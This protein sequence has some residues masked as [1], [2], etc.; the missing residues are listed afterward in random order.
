MNPNGV[1]HHSP[2][3]RRSRYPGLPAPKTSSTPR[4]LRHLLGMNNPLGVGIHPPTLPRVGAPR[5]P[6][7]GGFSPV[8]AGRGGLGW[9]RALGRVSKT[10]R[11]RDQ[12]LS[13][14][15][16]CRAVRRLAGRDLA[17]ATPG[18]HPPTN[19]LHFGLPCD[20]PAA[21]GGFASTEPP[22]PRTPYAASQLVDDFSAATDFIYGNPEGPSVA[23]Q[24]LARS[25][26][27]RFSGGDGCGCRRMIVG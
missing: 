1:R 9:D 21:I 2:G 20:T 3:L 15:G 26:A 7:A 5:Q 6:R 22:H 13:A 10:R 12:T 25:A 23:L 8:G 11:T 4:G 27:V 19:F 18:I 16:P 24:R 17:G 14:A